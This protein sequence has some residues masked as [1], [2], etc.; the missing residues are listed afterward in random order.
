[1]KKNTQTTQAPM[2]TTR[3][4][5]M[6]IIPLIIEQLLNSLMG[7]A[8]T[9]MVSRVGSAA[10][11]AASLVDSINNVILQIFIAMSVGG[12]VVC[13]QYL[14]RRDH[15]KAQEAA[16]QV[17]LTT[18]V[19]ALALTFLCLTFGRPLLRLIYGSVEEAVMENSV[20]YF[21]YTAIS[22]PFI[23]LYN[24]SAAVYRAEGN[25]RVPMIVSVTSNVLNIIGNALLI[26]SFH[27]GIAGAA[28]ATLAARVFSAVVMTY[29]LRR[30]GRVMVVKNYGSIRPQYAMILAILTIGVPNGIENGMFH[31]GKLAIQSSLSILSTASLAAQ[32]MTQT[33]EYITS[34]A[35]IGMGLA[36][37]TVV[38]QCMGAGRKE[39]AKHY[40]RLMTFYAEISL[41]LVGIL[42]ALIVPGI[43][44][45]AG[46]E[47][48][49]AAL[50]I[51]VSRSICLM[52]CFTWAN[53]FIIAYGLRAAG[54]VKFCMIYSM[55]TMWLCRVAVSVILIR[56]T[57]LG[58]WG[59]WIGMFSD[60]FVRG[61]GFLIRYRSGR[62]ME[63]QVIKD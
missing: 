28:I 35:G 34:M 61:I 51:K 24:T 20:I 29:L 36:L 9:M 37:V 3:A 18:T 58:I 40:I 49:S 23:A 55:C 14:G 39:E 31:F 21:R 26:F 25:S 30:P 46:M 48:E 7:T 59:M 41:I 33:L 10:I 12:T 45:L 16:R 38:G 32:A 5:W 62:W 15:N 4:L 17:M 54:D 27:M 6:L 52:K 42:V 63:H 13:S 8:D 50:C 53:A 2:F 57:S 47:P 11:T 1:M 60:W 22:Y 43:T 56:F 44:R 19:I